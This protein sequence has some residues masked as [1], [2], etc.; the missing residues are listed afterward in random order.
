MSLPKDLSR[1]STERTVFEAAL[2]MVPTTL[3]YT[4]PNAKAAAHFRFRA[5][6]FRRLA[7]R[8]G[9]TRFNNFVLRIVRNDV[10]FETVSSPTGQ[11]STLSGEPVPLIIL[12][13]ISEELSPEEAIA[14]LGLEGEDET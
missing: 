14:G 5:Y 2:T 8:A 4:L 11:L 10:I 1:Y 3:K 12:P 13:E 9:D 7:E 6:Q